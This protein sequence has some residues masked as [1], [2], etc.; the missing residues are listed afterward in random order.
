MKI[1]KYAAVFACLLFGMY[2]AGAED[3]PEKLKIE[4]PG[5][6]ELEMIRV[7][8]GS[9]VMGKRSRRDLQKHPTDLF[10]QEH[11]VT[12]KNDFYLGKYEVTEKQYSAVSGRRTRSAENLP[13]TF[14]TWYDAMKF[15]DKLN[16]SGK[17]PEGY[18]FSL[19]TETQWEYA[20]RGGH[21]SRNY[22][23][24]G[25]NDPE[26]IMY[27]EKGRV[28]GPNSRTFSYTL[29]PVGEKGRNELGFHDMSG[30]ALE[31]C[32]DD[33][34]FDG[35]KVIPE[36]SRESGDESPKERTLRGGMVA[37]SLSFRSRPIFR[38]ARRRPD[39]SHGFTGFRVA[40][41]PADTESLADAAIRLDEEAASAVPEEN[42]TKETEKRPQ[43]VKKSNGFVIDLAENCQLEL[44][45]I[46]AG[47]FFMG[48]VAKNKRYGHPGI[49][50]QREI[51]EDSFYMGIYE[52]TQAQWKA[53][54]GT[55]IE[56]VSGSGPLCG[57]GDDYPI[58]HLNWA[59][60]MDFCDRL[61]N[62]GKA[63]KGYK[64]SLPTDLQWEY[65]ARGSSKGKAYTYAG[66][67]DAESVGW[68]AFNSDVSV[69]PVGEKKPNRL[70]LYDMS[71]NVAEI[72]LDYYFRRGNDRDEKRTRGKGR[73]K[74][75]DREEN[76]TRSDYK[77]YAV[78]GGSWDEK[79]E[80][81]PLHNKSSR[82]RMSAGYNPGRI[83]FSLLY[84]VGFR[85]VLIPDTEK[86]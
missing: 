9:F 57:V 19:P 10:S 46:P 23:Y 63:P 64:F 55:D 11:K 1:Q 4:L 53:V 65:A 60:A 76:E 44:V 27:V 51:I 69:H 13:C 6:A 24:S 36:F 32:L 75:D 30:N 18:K 81:S 77:Y 49:R 71:G 80:L 42:K 5:G 82:S 39:V 61:N 48:E 83:S 79:A 78:R 3:L 35:R 7:K 21:K 54:M 74:E 26:E 41:I 40:L 85:V 34:I 33:F 17:A 25:S 38:E 15:C 8:A 14:V 45:K 50:G 52:V 22:T 84:N 67:D 16:H 2:C 73:D 62:S 47:P 56:K 66:S 37:N 20:A 86:E 29:Q 31:W 70:G 58:Y 12:L 59:D 43:R 28:T 72:C 68:F